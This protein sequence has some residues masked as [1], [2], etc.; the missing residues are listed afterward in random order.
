MYTIHNMLRLGSK[1]VCSILLVIIILL[2]ATNTV[3]ALQQLTNPTF[4]GNN[5]WTT[6]GKVNGNTAATVNYHQY[7][8]E[9]T[10]SRSGNA[11]TYDNL[12]LQQ[13]RIPANPINV[14]FSWGAWNATSANTT[15]YA[16]YTKTITNQNYRLV[17][18]TTNNNENGT[19]LS[20][21]NSDGNNEAGTSTV[22]NLPQ[23]QTYYAKIY[24]SANIS[25]KSYTISFSSF[26]VNC[27]PA[28]LAATLN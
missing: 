13:F 2:A 26:E 16:W 15:N 18:G 14:R 8:L 1:S 17:Y 24:C 22:T 28:G 20:S 19:E 6:H 12:V 23:N 11:R 9:I 4:N 10:A 3:F 25:Y 7:N 5:G 27:S 21:R